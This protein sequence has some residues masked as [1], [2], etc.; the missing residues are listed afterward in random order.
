MCKFVYLILHYNVIDETVKSVD[1]IKNNASGNYKIIIVDNASPNG[2]AKDLRELYESDKDIVLLFND[3]NLGFAK[4]NNVGFLYAKEKLNPEYIVMLNND[5]YLLDSD[6]QEKIEKEYERSKFGLLGPMIMT[7]D[8][9]CDINPFGKTDYSLEEVQITIEYCKRQIRLINRGLIGIY[10]RVLSIRDSLKKQ[11][12]ML[13]NKDY[14]HRKEDV[15]LHGSCL[16]FS[17]EYI[18]KFDGMNP[19]TFLYGEEKILCIECKR[20]H[21]TI[22]YNPDIRVFHNEHASTKNQIKKT[23]K[24]QLFFYKNLLQSSYVLLEEIKK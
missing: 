15:L 6:T 8:G 21:L 18:K 11:K 12:Y 24:Q 20:N 13:A 7:A 1:S 5:V 16:I 23:K 22:V 4:G 9:K 3:E 10:N 2:T 17:K 19:K 14:I